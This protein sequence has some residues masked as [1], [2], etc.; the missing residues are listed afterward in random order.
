MK[1]YTTIIALLLCF[2][3][4]FCK[5]QSLVG[6]WQLIKQTTCLEEPAPNDTSNQKGIVQNLTGQDP[7]IVRFIDQQN[8]E[9][10]AK[11]LNTRKSSGTKNFMYKFDGSTLYILD[12]RTRT[13]AETY[14]IDSFQG[15]SL[16]ISNTARACETRVF[17]K[18]K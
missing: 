13:I 3:T 4:C 10:S 7:I 18:L 17:V 6:S 14:D 12:K 9:E 16:I 5:A 1:Q 11:I 2:M 15:D 8:G